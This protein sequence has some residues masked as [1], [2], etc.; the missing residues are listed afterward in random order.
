[1]SRYAL[2]AAYSSKKQA[3]QPFLAM[4]PTTARQTAVHPLVPLQ[5]ALGNR[6]VAEL[7]QTKRL[8]TETGF[9][10]QPQLT[11]GAA[12]DHYEQE[13]DTIANR[14][15]T[16][17]VPAAS[18]AI[19]CQTLPEE[20]DEDKTLQTKPL[21]SSITPLVQ[22]QAM[23]E[24]EEQ[25]PLQPKLL[26]GAITPT[27]QRQTSEEEENK[28]V[29]AKLVND[30]GATV[31][32][33]MGTEEEEKKPEQPIQAKPSA[34]RGAGTNRFEV[35]AV[36]E[37]QVSRS[38]GGGSPLPDHVRGYMEPRFGVDFSGVR[39][40]TG[41]EA[42]E[43]NRAV[44]AQAFTHGQ[45]IYFGTGKGA[46]VSDLTAH[47][48][49]HVVQQTGGPPHLP[50][51]STV[52]VA[53]PRRIQRYTVPGTLDCADVV[54][55]LDT[56]SPYRPEWAQTACTYT[57]NGNLRIS[58]PATSPDGVS[59]T[60]SGH[61]GLSVSVSCPIDSP[62]WSPSSRPNRQAEVT[63]WRGMK[64]VLDAHE[65]QHR[66]IGRTW[67]ATLE[68]RFQGIH[69]TVTG[70]NQ[71]EAMR[72]VQEEVASLQQQWTAEAQAAQDAIDPF[73]GAV[74]NCP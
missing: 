62:Q 23:P 63:A 10:I 38:K 4:R 6:A 15:M 61:R 49:T 55:W 59:L 14:V 32:R 73:R 2:T 70:A 22:R 64:A 19:Q 31:Q 72:M 57:F 74:L 71:A 47:E 17:P 35:G 67:R 13:A 56:N 58:P 5:Q 30:S 18:Q 69:F 39:V 1:M 40:H 33:E 50:S 12:G 44:G 25:K 42:A 11:V 7:I 51:P 21:A 66:A 29:Q 3:K 28:P 37:N 54:D 24:E 34:Q 27:V 16:M 26:V 52:S 60:V 9:V 53:A 46:D 8:T 36:F 68:T 20:K 45:D 48:L 43:L 41:H 65:Q